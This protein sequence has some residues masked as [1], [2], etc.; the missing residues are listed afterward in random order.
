MNDMSLESTIPSIKELIRGV[1]CD[2]LKTHSDLNFT[3]T[4]GDWQ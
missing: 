4:A 3:W 1:L 2:T